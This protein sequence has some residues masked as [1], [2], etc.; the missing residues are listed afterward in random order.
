ME[1]ERRNEA[2]W[3]GLICSLISRGWRAAY[4]GLTS[5]S[6]PSKVLL[7]ALTI[8]DFGAVRS[9][10]EA[11]WEIRLRS[12]R[13]VVNGEEWAGSPRRPA[14]SIHPYAHIV[15]DKRGDR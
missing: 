8:T 9:V 4:Y 2:L 10:L 15:S 5:R 7:E 3:T 14:S 1:R 13:C 6:A 12:L 11:A